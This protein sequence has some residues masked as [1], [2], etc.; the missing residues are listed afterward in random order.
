M[1]WLLTLVY[2]CTVGLIYCWSIYIVSYIRSLC[3][4]VVG[5]SGGFVNNSVS[6]FKTSD[7]MSYRCLRNNV[8]TVGNM[9][10]HLDQLKLEAFRHRKTK[11]IIGQRKLLPDCKPVHKTIY[12]VL[13][14]YE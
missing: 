14:L 9:T 13:L 1:Y 7:N 4:I 10:L 6:S 5:E 12:N 2:R 3:S 11:E 8:V